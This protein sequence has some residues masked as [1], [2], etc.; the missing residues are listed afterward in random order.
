MQQCLVAE[1]HVAP[2][3][4]PSAYTRSTS[5]VIIHLSSVVV[6]Q[7]KLY[8]LPRPHQLCTLWA[9]TV[10]LSSLAAAAVQCWYKNP[11]PELQALTLTA[12]Q[13]QAHLATQDITSLQHDGNVACI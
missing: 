7:C 1:Q 10:W 6:L 11:A 12:Q 4:V 3:A 2:C 13:L 9:A 5:L 8:G